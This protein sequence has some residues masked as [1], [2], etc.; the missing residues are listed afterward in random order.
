MASLE[1]TAYPRFKR[2]ISERELREFFTPS[3]EEVAWAREHT[4]DRPDRV[5]ALLVMLKSAARLGRVPKLWEIPEVVVAHVRDQAGLAAETVP[6]ADSERSEERYRSAVRERLELRHKPGEARAVAEA[7]MR[8]AAPVKAH[9]ADLVNVALEEL[10]RQKERLELPAFSTLDRMASRIRS[11]VEAAQCE[12]IVSRMSDAALERGAGMLEVAEGEYQSLFAWIKQPAR[13][14][15]W[16]RFRAH[17]ERMERVDGLGDAVFWVGKTPPA[18]VAALAEQARVL[19]VGEMKDIAEPRRTALTVCLLAQVQATVRDETVVMLSK[20]MSRHLKRAQEELLEIEKRQKE[21]TEQLLA[22]FR[23]VLTALRGSGEAAPGGWEGEA[24][25]DD[26]LALKNAR[27][28]IETAGGFEAQLAEL[29]ALDAYRGS[30]YTALVERFFSVL[31]AL[32]H[33]LA[34]QHLTRPLVADTHPTRKDENGKQVRLD[35]SFA[36]KM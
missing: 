18:K 36:P 35:L 6:E 1:R 25:L 5:L 7:A 34:H 31:D 19:S 13:R 11:E 8:A 4:H 10:V 30:N 16:S 9:T 15:T 2:L 22:T 33:V 21:T 24:S 14:A 23:D 32:D 3:A 27:A 29:E 28:A 26:L 17:A 12:A 20:R